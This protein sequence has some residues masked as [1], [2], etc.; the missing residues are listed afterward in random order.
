M[1][2]GKRELRKL[3][4]GLNHKFRIVSANTKLLFGKRKS[5]PVNIGSV[6]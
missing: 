4:K 2:S 5:N 6:A 3:E 1:K